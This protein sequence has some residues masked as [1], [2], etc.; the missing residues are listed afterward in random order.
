M[1]TPQEKKDCM[2]IIKWGRYC[3]GDVGADGMIQI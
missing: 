2:I 3:L 1:H